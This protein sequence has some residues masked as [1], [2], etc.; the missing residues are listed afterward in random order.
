MNRT[1]PLFAVGIQLEC[2]L[3]TIH[4]AGRL[5]AP[6]FQRATDGK[7]SDAQSAQLRSGYEL[8]Q[9]ALNKL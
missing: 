1:L 3:E 7:R 2:G 8:M 5:L 4:A 6:T 9:N